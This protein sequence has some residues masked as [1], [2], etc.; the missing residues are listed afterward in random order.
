MLPGV[1]AAT[2]INL[3]AAKRAR[4]LDAAIAEFAE[5]G[6]SGGSLTVVA[7]EAGV[8]KGSLLVYF[9]D[10]LDLFAH[11]CDVVSRRIRDHMLAVL[12]GHGD[13]GFFATL[14]AAV[15]AWIDYFRDHPLDRGIT[16]AANFELDPDVRAAVRAVTN[17]HHLEVLE[18]L[19]AAAH[20]NHELRTDVSTDSLVALLVLLLPHLALAPFA[21]DLDP[22]LG[23]HGLD[24][25]ALA[26]P[27]RGLLSALER[28]FSA[29]AQTSALTR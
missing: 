24:R 27:V 10:K 17:R 20:A 9:D 13:L 3:D 11:V 14:D 28:A 4:V 26:V 29:A 2:W 15:V 23:M 19:V 12:A 5:K 25:N 21:A 22:V 1:P 18:P 16:H 6:F 8:A 7:Q